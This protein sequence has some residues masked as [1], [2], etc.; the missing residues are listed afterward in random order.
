MTSL[1]I[2]P[3]TTPDPSSLVVTGAIGS[4]NLKW[5]VPNDV[6]YVS[7]QVFASSTNSFS[8]ATLIAEVTGSS[9]SYKSDTGSTVY[10]WVRGVDK[11]GRTNG[12]VIPSS[13]TG[14]SGAAVTVI[15]NDIAVNAVTGTTYI[16]AD[17]DIDITSSY[18]SFTEVLSYSVTG[19]GNKFAFTLADN[20]TFDTL[21]LS[22]NELIRI[23]YGVYLGRASAPGWDYQF[24]FDVYN[25]QKTSGG[26]IYTMK[27]WDFNH[28]FVVTLPED[29]ETYDL[30]FQVGRER[31][32]LSG[33]GT[34][35]ST[36]DPKSLA[37]RVTITE[38]KR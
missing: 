21:S 20:W 24:Q 14:T 5:Q 9:Y 6:L 23:V 28:S 38:L 32:L 2:T 8:S 36:I 13:T 18:G 7:T 34:P 16:T 26:D 30:Y 15:T 22:S 29:P 31:E 33:T 19:T 35:T 27:A 4:I 3:V 1:V 12:N 17:T 25:I 11:Y 37:R 10:F